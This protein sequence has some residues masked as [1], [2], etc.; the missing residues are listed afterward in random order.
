MSLFC[1]VGISGFV[2]AIFLGLG[3]FVA[4]ILSLFITDTVSY[5]SKHTIL[6]S[7][8]CQAYFLTVYVH[9]VFLKFGRKT[10]LLCGYLLMTACLMAASI[11][12]LVFGLESDVLSTE[13]TVAGYFVAVFLTVFVGAGAAGAV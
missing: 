13:K 7:A 11:L 4:Q 6:H 1:K 8:F 2:G 3:I 10:I 9:I 12:I 5:V